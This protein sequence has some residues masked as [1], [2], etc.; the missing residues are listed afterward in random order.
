MDS[1]R[2]SQLIFVQIGNR[3]GEA[4]KLQWS[5]QGTGPGLRV[6]LLQIFESLTLLLA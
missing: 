6:A 5:Y 1:S 3:R 4:T 2:L